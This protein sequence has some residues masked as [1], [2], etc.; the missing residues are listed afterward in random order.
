MRLNPP[1]TWLPVPGGIHRIGFQEEGF[2]FDNELPVHEVLLPD[3]ELQ[4]RLVTNAE[5]LQ[6]MEAGGYGDFRFWMGEGWVRHAGDVVA[7]VAT[8]GVC[9]VLSAKVFR[10][11]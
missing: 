5:Y 1:A 2:C 4:N 11:E 3:F 8:F 9:M 10:W 6:F 7:L